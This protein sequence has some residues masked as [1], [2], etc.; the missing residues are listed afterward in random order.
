[1]LGVREPEVYGTATPDDHIATFT[2]TAKE[3]G[4]TV[5][6][7]QSNHEGDFVDAIQ[8]ARGTHRAIV[9]NAGAFS[10]YAWAI[11]DALAAFDGPIIELH[12]SNP[13]A[14]ERWRRT[15]VVSPVATGVIQGFGGYGYRLSAQA[16]AE[17]L[18]R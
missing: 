17:L 9:I 10:H 14:R 7:M 5:D 8:A 12:I 6:H 16:V 1:M 18:R 11:H 15:S 4:L 13:E 3:E 2:E